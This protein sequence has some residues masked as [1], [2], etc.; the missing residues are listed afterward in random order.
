MPAPA[1]ARVLVSL[2]GGPQQ[3]GDVVALNGDVVQ[4]SAQSVAGFDKYR[5][6]V[7]SYPSGWST[8]AGWNLD[9]STGIV[10]ST[11][12]SPPSFTLP[13]LPLWGKWLT[14]LLINE[15]LSNDEARDPSLGLN[16]E[17]TIVNVLSPNNLRDTAGQ[18]TT[19]ADAF[20]G[21]V[22]DIAR[23]W[24]VIDAALSGF[25]PIGTLTPGPGNTLFVNNPA[26]S[27]VINALLVDANVS[28]IA[29]IAGTKISPNFGPQAV[30]T[31]GTLSAGS[32]TV[33]ALTVGSLSGILHAASGVISASPVSL[34]ADVSGILPPPNGGT[35]LSAVVTGLLVGNGSTY[36]GVTAPD[37]RIP[38]WS[39]NTLSSSSG[40]TFASSTLSVTNVTIATALTLSALAATNGPLYITGGVVGVGPGGADAAT[41]INV[42]DRTALANRDTANLLDGSLAIVR[43]PVSEYQLVKTSTTT[44]DGFSFIAAK[45]GGGTLGN[46]ILTD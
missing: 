37:T 23:N 3:T 24:R 30:A 40:L 6:E 27:A 16:D 10:F 43:S 17:S 19:Q 28:A 7:Y 9:S 44:P 5:W 46:W 4:L 32:T 8:P 38:F 42:A 25:S 2:N 1:F 31:T 34:T 22:G 15:A 20:R 39:S 12:L 36:S 33:S 11:A 13:A 14:R 29:A 35:G 18:E 41:N 45:N 21:F 26:G